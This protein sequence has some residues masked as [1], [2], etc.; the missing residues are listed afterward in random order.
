MPMW[1]CGFH[2]VAACSAERLLLIITVARLNFS[3]HNIYRMW[4][5]CKHVT[6][7]AI[8]KLSDEGGI[9]HLLLPET[10]IIMDHNTNIFNA[11]H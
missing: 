5:Y 9:P 7:T 11:W 3:V 2:E 1:R 10:I 4:S 8:V 6:Y